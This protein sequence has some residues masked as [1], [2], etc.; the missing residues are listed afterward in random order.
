MCFE[1]DIEVFPTLLPVQ[2]VSYDRH[3]T[4]GLWIIATD[5]TQNLTLPERDKT[6]SSLRYTRPVVGRIMGIPH[7]QSLSLSNGK[8]KLHDDKEGMYIM[9]S[10]ID[11]YTYDPSTIATGLCILVE[12]IRTLCP[13]EG[14]SDIKAQVEVFD[15]NGNPV[16]TTQ[17]PNISMRP[18]YTTCLEGPLF[19]GSTSDWKMMMKPY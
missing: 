8:Y 14:F 6:T 18:G 11:E 17:L 19:S 3:L 4:A 10:V 5:I 1:K 7:V 12:D 2:Q 9:T 15:V 16:P 13:P